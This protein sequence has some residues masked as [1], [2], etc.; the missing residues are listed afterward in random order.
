MANSDIP[1]GFQP[2]RH[3]G[4]GVIR[5]SSYKLQSAYSTA[6]GIGDA[7]IL[8]SGYINRAADNSATILGIFAG[9]RYRASDGSIVFTN[10]WPASTATLGSEDAEALVWDDPMISYRC[11]SDTGTD[12]VDATHK[13]GAYDIELDHSASSITGIS[14]MEID[15]GDTGTGQFMVLGLIDEPNNAAGTNAK[16]EVTIKESL[17]K[18]N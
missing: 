6:L 2:F 7:V 17:L 14:G 16:I 13:G 10:Y 4:G 15:L 1:M 18:G 3:R 8:S 12:Y 9:V 11:Q 5:A